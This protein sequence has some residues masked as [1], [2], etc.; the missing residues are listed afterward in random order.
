LSE[1]SISARDLTGVAVT[2]APGLVGSLVVGVAFAKAYALGL[3][4]PVVGVNHIEAHL[5]SAVL[6]H[7]DTPLPA[8]ALVVSGGH[9]ELVEI[10]AIGKYR[11]LGGTRDDAAGEAYDKV[12]KLLGLGFPGGPPIDRLAREGR[13]DAFDFPRPMLDRPGFDVSFSGLKTAVALAVAGQPGPPYERAWVADVAASFQAAVVD[14]LVGKT[15]RAIQS[16]NARALNLG[17]GVACNSELRSRLH[18]ECARLGVSLRVPSPRLCADNAAMIA[19]VGAWRLAGETGSQSDLDA[20]AALE[21][22]GFLT[23]A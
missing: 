19:L 10:E 23:P 11:W 6:E 22:S 20:A 16:T 3:G 15:V 12:A 17:G 14:T 18:F 7:G 1:A 13:A 21:D 9:T 4:I 2:H 8:V 5:H